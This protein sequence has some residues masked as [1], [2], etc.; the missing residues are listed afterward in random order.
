MDTMELSNVTA[1]PDEGSGVWYYA[2]KKPG[3][4]RDGSG[5]PQFNVLS[6]GAVS[7]LQ[8]TGSW[9]VS[10]AD[11]DSARLELAGKLRRNPD[12]VKFRPAPER[13]NSV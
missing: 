6:A 5:R 10:S 2:P 3:I 8:I 12:S 9:G 13:V 11:A 1:I 7:F 4:A